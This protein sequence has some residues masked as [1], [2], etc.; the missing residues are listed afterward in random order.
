MT[1][2]T[3]AAAYV[4]WRRSALGWITD[5]LEV[6]VLIGRIGPVRGL[7]ILDA[8]CGDGALATRLALN[9]ANVTGLDAS[10]AVIV[11]VCRRAEAASVGMVLVP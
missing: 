1:S 3:L 2:E 10:A 7:D 5:D 6:R 4:D 9:G 11:A 8:G